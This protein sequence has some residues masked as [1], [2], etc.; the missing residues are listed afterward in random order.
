MCCLRRVTGPTQPESNG[1]G[2]GCM[3]LV[4]MRNEHKVYAID[5][6]EEAPA[7][8]SEDAFC[9]DATCASAWPFYPERVTGGHPVGVPGT[10]A[11]TAKL[12]ERF[13][14]MSLQA[15]MAPAIRA[16]RNGVPM[17]SHLHSRII[18]N[19][20]RL[21]LFPA[22]KKLFLTDAGDPIVRISCGR[23]W[24]CVW[25]CV[26]VCVAVC[27]AEC[28]AVCVCGCVCVWL[29]VYVYGC[30]STVAS[31]PAAVAVCQAPIGGLW[32]NEDL[33][34][35]LEQI[36]REGIGALY[37]GAIGQVSSSLLCVTMCSA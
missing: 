36:G 17:T 32:K 21:S 8:F 15:V 10:L 27:V 20:D 3:P 28:V 33:A 2:G 4:Y 7:A 23:V 25:L 1:I 9:Q 13:G 12:L 26:A 29:C 37:G 16:A 5:G 11:A 22:S 35:T 30:S 34:A 6:R 24:L 14:T 31:L 19:K 18:A